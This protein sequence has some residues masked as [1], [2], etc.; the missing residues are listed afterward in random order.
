MRMR[1]ISERVRAQCQIIAEHARAVTGAPRA[2]LLLYDETT[3]RLVT[4]A[5]PG[6]ELPLQQVAVDLIRRNY[7]GLDP[8]DLSYRPT[9]NPIVSAAFIGQRTQ[10][11]TMEE[12]FENILPAPVSAIARGLLRV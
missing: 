8:L 3:R 5:T 12:A 2:I 1:G 6:S 10:V 9:I 4:V 7:P 11:S